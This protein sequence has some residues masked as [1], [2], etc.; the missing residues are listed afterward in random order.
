MRGLPSAYVDS[1]ELFL[2]DARREVVDHQELDWFFSDRSYDLGYQGIVGGA[3]VPDSDLVIISVHRDSRLVLHD[4]VG[5]RKVGEIDLAGRGRGSPTPRFR[6]IAR[7]LWVDDYDTLVRLDPLDWRLLDALQLQ[8]GSMDPQAFRS[9]FLPDLELPSLQGVEH[10]AFIG[11]FAFN[12]DES[13][14]AVARPFSGDVLL[15]DTRA[16]KVT[17]RTVTGGYP[18]DLALMSNGVIFARAW[19]TGDLLPSSMWV[20]YSL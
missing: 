11:E 15:L 13:A 5:R 4:P 17:A 14:C 1:H 8:P 18:L 16:F 7:E 9:P 20:P 12:L 2:L 10:R 6:K 3:E 19:N